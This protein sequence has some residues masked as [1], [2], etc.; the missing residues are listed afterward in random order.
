MKA[1]LGL[2]IAATLVA[3]PHA[4][5]QRC[6]YGPNS[7]SPFANSAPSE[8]VESRPAPRPGYGSI[9]FRYEWRDALIQPDT[10]PSS[11]PLVSC[12][13]VGSPAQ[14]AGLRPGDTIVLVNGRDPRL[15]A[16]FADRRVG[17]QWVVRVERDGKQRDVA[18]VIAPRA[19][20]T[21]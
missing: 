21:G 4:A 16:S 20:T 5:A 6:D 15:R 1:V 9:G 17:A 18:F 7:T 11:L 12:V 3:T 10:R 2:A 14:R 8:H 13:V 19:G